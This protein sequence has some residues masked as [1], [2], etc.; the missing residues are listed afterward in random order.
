M[1][2]NGK[3]DILFI[4]LDTMRKDYTLMLEKELSKYNFISYDRAI[5]PAPWT[6]PSHASIFSGMYP[7]F[8]GVHESK[9]RKLTDVFFK[10]GLNN[11]IISLKNHKY[12]TCL[13]SSNNFVTP[14]YGF[15]PFDHFFYVHAFPPSWNF[16]SDQERKII[17]KMKFNIDNPFQMINLLHN[18]DVKI[19]ALKYISETTANMLIRFN[20]KLFFNWPK[21]KGNRL[22]TNKVKDV[23][24]KEN[25]SSSDRYPRFIFVNFMEVHEP[26]TINEPVSFLDNLKEN[27]ASERNLY[28]WKK[29]YKEFSEYLNKNII[30]LIK[31]LE[32]KLDNMLIIITSDHGQLLG[33]HGNKVGHGTYLYD[34]LLRVPFLIRYPDSWKNKNSLERWETTD[35]ESWLS[36]IKVKDIIE[37][38]ILSDSS[39]VS[40]KKI[41]S[42]IVFSESYG[43][44]RRVSWLND[45]KSLASNGKTEEMEI[46]KKITHLEK[47]R[48]AIYYKNSKVIFNVSDWKIESISSFSDKIIDEK[49]LIYE[50][51]KHVMNFIKTS[52]V[53][54]LVR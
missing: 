46:I 41:L 52:T 43:I 50:V 37:K 35:T 6:T 31:N 51:K 14:I 26:Y 8:H 27:G 12:K 3:P 21:N 2:E 49:A 39:T 4:V 22:L 18:S 20:A 40:K 53:R 36:L 29:K 34:E 1:L 45:S 28:V 30:T 24:L 33:E 44:H 47:Y 25:S 38:V 17:S 10:K 16:L 15:K 54:S 11:L 48:I 32:D 7:A 19:T 42:D 9:R 13:F 5:S 23:L